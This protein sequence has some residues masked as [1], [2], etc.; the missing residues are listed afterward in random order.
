MAKDMSIGVLNEIYGALIS[1][2]QSEFIRMYYDF[3]LSLGEIAENASVT[4][5]AVMDSIQKG[6]KTLKKMEDT[7][8]INEKNAKLKARIESLKECAADENL[9]KKAADEILSEL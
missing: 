5:Q 2:K 6:V 7:L 3:D 8:K 4:R 1:E 9:V